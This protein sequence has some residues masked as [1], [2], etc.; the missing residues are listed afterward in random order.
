MKHDKKEAKMSSKP[1]KKLVGKPNLVSSEFFDAAREA[2]LREGHHREVVGDIAKKM[3]VKPEAEKT[4]VPK[5]VV[6][7]GEVS[8]DLIREVAKKAATEAVAEERKRGRTPAPTEAPT[9]KPRFEKGSQE[10]REFMA[11]VR[12]GKSKKVVE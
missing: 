1:G 11:R 10:A 2:A 4:K 5:K 9:R 7:G 12:A 6:T 8:A 3:E